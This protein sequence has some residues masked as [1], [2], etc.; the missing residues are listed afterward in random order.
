MIDV[1]IDLKK[2]E[3]R[4]DH[5]SKKKKKKSNHFYKNERFS[6]NEKK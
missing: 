3:S 1:I 2:A 6:K 5:R 4:K